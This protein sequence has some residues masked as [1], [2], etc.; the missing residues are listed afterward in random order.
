MA[1]ILMYQNWLNENRIFEEDLSLYI[2]W[3]GKWTRKFKHNKYDAQG[4]K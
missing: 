4:W 3:K 2:D 1:N